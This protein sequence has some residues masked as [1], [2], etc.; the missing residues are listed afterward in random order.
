MKTTNL[1]NLY[2]LFPSY[3]YKFW[4]GH[5][6][7]ILTLNPMINFDEDLPQ[8]VWGHLIWTQVV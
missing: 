7:H 3:A 5:D 4:V 8:I 6:M 1:L 2:I